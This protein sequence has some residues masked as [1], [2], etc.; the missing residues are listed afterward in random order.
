MEALIKKA[1]ILMEALPYIKQFSGKTFVIK[2]GGKAMVDGSLKDSVIE[3]I[4]LM[5]YIGIN[6]VVVHGG[7]PE[8]TEE[9]NKLG[10]KSVFKNGLRVTDK[11]TVDIAEKVLVGKINKE[12]VSLVHK[13]GGKAIGLSGKDGELI[14]AKKHKADIGFVGEVEKINFHVMDKL[15]E[16]IPVI[17]PI[18]IGRDGHTYNVNA[19]DVASAIATAIKAEKLILLTDVN[20]VLDKDKKLISSIKV[21]EAA[22]LEK[23]GIIS[24][25]MIPKVNSC[26][27]AVKQGVKKVHIINGGIKHSMLLEIFTKTGVGTEFSE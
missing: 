25:G 1:D 19:D 21:N 11:E 24:G 13:H 12:I 14:I 4:V 10:K 20:G 5:K 27:E 16:F 9:M 23:S 6:P 26:V 22:K 15:K 3:D 17:S 7:A 18:A 2:Y 8:I